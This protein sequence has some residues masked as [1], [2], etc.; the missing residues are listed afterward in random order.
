MS[1][2]TIWILLIAQ[3]IIA[4]AGLLLMRDSL[5]NLIRGSWNQ[6]FGTLIK[7][8]SGLIAYLLSVILWFY[9]LSKSP[10]TF[11]YP[12]AIGLTLV[13]TLVVSALWLKEAPNITQIAGYLLLV[14]AIFLISQK[15]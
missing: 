2:K 12:V 8:A 3:S 5:P 1:S 13:I 9:I 6:D 4:S 11:A 15:S 10:L 7:I 14:V